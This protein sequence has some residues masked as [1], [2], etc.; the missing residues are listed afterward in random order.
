MP[1]IPVLSLQ[2]TPGPPGDPGLTVSSTALQPPVLFLLGQPW[3]CRAQPGKRTGHQVLMLPSRG[4]L[5]L[6]R[7][8]KERGEGVCRV[9]REREAFSL[10]GVA[11]A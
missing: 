2:G 9:G 10:E 1:E 4:G 8:A 7:G 6:P 11:A 5:W 3:L